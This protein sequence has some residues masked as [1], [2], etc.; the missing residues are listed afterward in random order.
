MIIFTYWKNDLTYL[1]LSVNTRNFLIRRNEKH[2][3][4]ANRSKNM[5]ISPLPHIFHYFEEETD[6]AT[7]YESS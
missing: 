1:G 5:M 7:D 4:E 2:E 3:K 6:D